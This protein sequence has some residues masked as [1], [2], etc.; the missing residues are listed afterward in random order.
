[1]AGL[2]EII[3]KVRRFG[4]ESLGLYYSS[5]PAYVTD[6][7][8]PLGQNRLHVIVPTIFGYPS[9][10]LWVYPR[11]FSPRVHDL[12]DLG[13]LVWVEFDNGRLNTGKWSFYAPLKGAKP[14][15]FKSHKVYGFKSPQG[16]LV[17]ISDLENFIEVKHKD[18]QVIKLF[19]DHTTITSSDIRLTKDELDQKSPLGNK[20]DSD[21][22]SALS[23]VVG[24]LSDLSTYAGTQAGVSQGPLSAYQVGY[25]TLNYNVQETKAQ[26]EQILTKFEDD[27]HLSDKVR[28]S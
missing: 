5:Y 4:L 12:P 23:K 19:E 7:Q 13:E 24:L 20:L 17:L 18:G 1:M 15:E 27:S 21:I 8:D 11:A 16:H 10:P 25:Q 14:E 28:L 26:L 2:K 6:N 3:E 22:H 9:K